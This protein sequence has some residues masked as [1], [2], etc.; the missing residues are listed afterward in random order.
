MLLLKKEM[1]KLFKFYWKGEQM[2]ILQIRYFF[3][4]YLFILKFVEIVFTLSFLFSLSL[5][6]LFFFNVKDGRTPLY[7]A[8]QKGHELIIQSLLERRANVNLP[9][10]VLLLILFFFFFLFLFLFLFI[11]YSYLFLLLFCYL[12]LLLIY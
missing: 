9:D 3:F 10:K 1:N 8:A 12:F 6:F 7:I 4:D 11:K 5:I 2:L